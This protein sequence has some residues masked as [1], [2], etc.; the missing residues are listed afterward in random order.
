MSEWIDLEE[1]PQ[2]LPNEG[3][4]VLFNVPSCYG[5]EKGRYFDGRWISDR[6]S[7]CND[8][9]SWEHRHGQVAHWMPLP[10]PPK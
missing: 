6:T 1:R 10:E 3:V 8:E 2:E 7:P 9:V 5:V 4:D